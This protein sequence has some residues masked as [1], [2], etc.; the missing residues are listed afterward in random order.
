MT[1]SLTSLGRVLARQLEPRLRPYGFA[2]AQGQVQG[3]GDAPTD[4]LYCVG[5]DVVDRMPPAYADAVER[6]Y[7]TQG[8]ACLDLHV[9]GSVATGIVEVEFE[10]AA[11]SDAL[12]WAGY[13]ALSSLTEALPHWPVTSAADF[14]AIS[15]EALLD[16]LDLA[17]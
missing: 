8:P 5:P 2:P 11:L 4:A 10:V 17:S 15:M 16:P 14:I 9:R 3:I 1:R 7:G 12:E 6:S 13:D